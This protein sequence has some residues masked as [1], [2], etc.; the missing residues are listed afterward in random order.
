MAFIS[1]RLS[2]HPIVYILT[3]LNLPGEIQFMSASM[4]G[5]NEY[6]QYLQPASLVIPI[7]RLVNTCSR[8]QN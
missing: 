3:S 5:S 8:I 1:F 2:I 7:Q 6:L 4:D